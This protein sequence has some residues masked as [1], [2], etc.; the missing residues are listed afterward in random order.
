MNS[1]TTRVYSVDFLLAILGYSLFVITLLSYYDID[2]NVVRF[3]G[4]GAWDDE[5]FYDEPSLSG[6]IYPGIEFNKRQQLNDDYQNLYEERLLRISTLPYDLVG[7]LDY[8]IINDY[9]TLNLPKNSLF[10]ATFIHKTTPL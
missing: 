3:V 6:S 10:Q 4:T 8:L 5:V 7:L 1:V 9:T 2:P